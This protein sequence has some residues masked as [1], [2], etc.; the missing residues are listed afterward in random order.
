M[1]NQFDLLDSIS[2]VLLAIPLIKSI[3]WLFLMLIFV[4][5]LALLRCLRVIVKAGALK[6]IKQF[7]GEYWR[8][9]HL[10]ENSLIVSLWISSCGAYLTVLLVSIGLED[11]TL[12]RAVKESPLLILY[13]IVS[14]LVLTG[15]TI[16]KTNKQVASTRV[17]VAQ[18]KKMRLYSAFKSVLKQ[19]Q[20]SSITGTSWGMWVG[21]AASATAWF[22]DHW[23]KRKIDAEMKDALLGFS[24]TAT[25][26]YLLRMSIVAVA[27]W[28]AYH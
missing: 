27:L 21:A 11:I 14:S 8:W 19:V 5:I 25:L 16:S 26:E 1:N 17:V 24:A 13:V 7:L 23:V 3:S 15:Y 9:N 2:Q 12:D 10:K 20:G 18:L 22:S 4:Q 28:S 6:D